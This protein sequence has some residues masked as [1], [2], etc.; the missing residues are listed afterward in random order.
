MVG[1][2]GAVRMSPQ[3]QS[4]S[5]Q[6]GEAGAAVVVLLQRQHVVEL[7]MAGAVVAPAVL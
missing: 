2:M 3:E 1:L 4:C 7:L 5:Q 6:V